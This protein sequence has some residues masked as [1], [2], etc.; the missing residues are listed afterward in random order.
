M[1]TDT[2]IQK[3]I[4]KILADAARGGSSSYAIESCKA[5][6]EQLLQEGLISR[7]HRDMLLTRVGSLLWQTPDAVENFKANTTWELSQG[8]MGTTDQV[9][10]GLV[11]LQLVGQKL[12]TVEEA[13]E[14][15]A[16]ALA[17]HLAT[18]P[19]DPAPA[20]PRTGPRLQS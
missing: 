20:I 9:E 4:A 3:R 18:P 19:A 13:I 10:L 1:T 16:Y 2:D 14:L 12:L 17:A 8:R 6:I 7:E 15:Q 5:Q 11:L